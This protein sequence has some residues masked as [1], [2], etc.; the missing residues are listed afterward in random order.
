MAGLPLLKGSLGGSYALNAHA[1]QPSVIHYL[2]FE[3]WL[4]IGGSFGAALLDVQ[5]VAFMYGVWE[6]APIALTGKLIAD[7]GTQ[8]SKL[9]WL[10]TLTV[11]CRIFGGGV[12]Q[13]YF[14]PKL[15]RYEVYEWDG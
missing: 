7:R 8:H 10:L 12:A 3:P 2:A 6:G 15:W 13:F 11:G 5:R 4:L 14:A 9:A 1:D